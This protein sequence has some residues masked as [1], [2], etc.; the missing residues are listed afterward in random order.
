M[1]VRR[2]VAGVDDQ[3]VRDAHRRV[4]EDLVLVVVLGIRRGHDLHSEFD[5]LSR[6][7][8]VGIHR[9]EGQHDQV[10]APQDTQG[11]VFHIA[12]GM[13]DDPVR[14]L[15]PELLGQHPGG[16]LVPPC[17][18]HHH[19]NGV[20]ADLEAVRERWRRREMRRVLAQMPVDL[21]PGR[22]PSIIH[23]ISVISSEG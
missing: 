14:E 6:E 5:G 20:A 1:V 15:R 8:V 9:G 18:A 22:H 11:G 21:F 23:D 12:T 2:A 10:G 16:A 19:D 3:V 4:V 7:G 17:G 13:G